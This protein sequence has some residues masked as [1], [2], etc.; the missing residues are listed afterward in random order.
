[1][2]ASLGTAIFRRWPVPAISQEAETRG[3]GDGGRPRGA[4]QLAADVRNVAVNGVRAQYELLCDLAV[5]QTAGD[6]GEDL[7]FTSREQDRLRF[8]R[9]VRRLLRREPALRGM[10]GRR[11]PCHHARGSARCP[12]AG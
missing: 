11:N 12:A 5:A 4:T 3:L 2:R 8:S 6:A 9:M 1:M 10:R 7:P